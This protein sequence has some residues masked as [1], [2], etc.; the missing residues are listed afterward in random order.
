MNGSFHNDTG[1]TRFFFYFIFILVALAS[2]VS[3]PD[4]G[5]VADVCL[6][7]EIIDL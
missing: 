2:P 6:Y 4:G 5:L 1:K 3:V 7:A